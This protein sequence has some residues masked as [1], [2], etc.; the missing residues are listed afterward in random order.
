MFKL[1]FLY[2]L[3]FNVLYYNVH[4]QHM[5]SENPDSFYFLDNI[6]SRKTP[7]TR[8]EREIILWILRKHAS[9]LGNKKTDANTSH[10]KKMAWYQIGLEYNSMEEVQEQVGFVKLTQVVQSALIYIRSI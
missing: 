3:Y 2:D 1:Q 8:R 5:Y 7:F 4:S 9:I 6:S 10:L